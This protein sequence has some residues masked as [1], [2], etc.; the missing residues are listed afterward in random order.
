MGP[1]H[2]DR[3]GFDS[4]IGLDEE[5]VAAEAGI[6]LAT[7]RVEDPE[8]RPSARRAGPVASDDHLR[9]LADDVASEMDPRP[10]RQLEPQPGRLGDRG[11]EAAHEVRR[12]EDDD[13][14]PGPPPERGEAAKPIADPAGLG[15]CRQVDDE[16]VDGST[17]EQRP[18]D[19]EALVEVRRGQDD[20]PLRS[21]AT[22]DGFDRVQGSGKVQPGDDRATGLGFSDVAERE[23]GPAA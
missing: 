18:G 23:R 2:K 8:G 1:R 16:Q 21:N 11:R 6:A 4:G 19:R 12:F 20:E 14:H 22:G 15:A 9:P 17:G 5:P 7:V 10:P 13:A 3:G